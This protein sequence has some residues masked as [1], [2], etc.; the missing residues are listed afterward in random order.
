MNRVI[1]L[2]EMD[3]EKMYVLE[4][5]HDGT[6]FPSIFVTQ[7]TDIFHGNKIDLD[8]KKILL[9]QEC[10]FEISHMMADLEKIYFEY[11]SLINMFENDKGIGKV[12]RYEAGGYRFKSPD[13]RFRKLF[14]DY[15]LQ[16]VSVY[17]ESTKLLESYTGN[18][19]DCNNK[20]IKKVMDE[21]LVGS[22]AYDRL[23]KRLGFIK[24]IYDLRG[25]L[26]HSEPQI[27]K[28][29]I[30]TVSN[31]LTFD[32]PKVKVKSKEYLL[33]DYMKQNLTEMILFVQDFA[34]AVIVKHKRPGIIINSSMDPNAYPN[35][36]IPMPTFND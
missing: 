2:Q 19:Y 27:S 35:Y 28:F 6:P 5:E 24:E 18:K 3:D 26:E 10:L 17:R 33:H 20:V 23:L 14:K 15:M 30:S 11:I 32:Y 8:G 4:Y 34:A 9:I 22:V 1:S 21:K 25:I 29:R 31:S 13:K 16:I 36:W 7:F 12:V